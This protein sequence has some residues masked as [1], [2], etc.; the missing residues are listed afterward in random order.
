MNPKPITRA[1]TILAAAALT[2]C[3]AKHERPMNEGEK[4]IV[5][6]QVLAMVDEA[7]GELDIREKKNVRC[8][9]IRITGTHMVTRL[10]YTSE[11]EKKIAE[12]TQE[13]YY[14]RFG[15]QKCLSGANCAGN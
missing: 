1:M 11:E 15:P 10:C 3:M 12:R 9:R 2:A 7:G 8:Q 13:E 4:T 14:R 6:D 5:S